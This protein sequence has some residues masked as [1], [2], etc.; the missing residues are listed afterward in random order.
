VASA[1]FYP[2]LAWSLSR[3]VPR[4]KLLWWILGIGCAFFVGFGR[5]YLGVHW[6]SDV[7]AGWVLGAGQT[8]L[9]LSLML[10]REA[11]PPGVG[12]QDLLQPTD[13]EAR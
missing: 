1:T 9:G 5:M 7:M 12:D 6:P 3:F 8:T 11:G 10:K 2:L 4:L 13:N